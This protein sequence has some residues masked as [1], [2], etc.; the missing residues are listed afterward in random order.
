MGE[1]NVAET[2]V[3][4]TEQQKE[5]FVEIEFGSEDE[6]LVLLSLLDWI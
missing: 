2:V 4:E 1:G 3:G 5:Y 6:F